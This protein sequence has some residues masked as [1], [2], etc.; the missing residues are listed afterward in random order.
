MQT[1]KKVT[2]VIAV[3]GVLLG[4]WWLRTNTGIGIGWI[5]LGLAVLVYLVV[6]DRRGRQRAF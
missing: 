4:I 2:Y 1:N 5:A 6:I 3:L